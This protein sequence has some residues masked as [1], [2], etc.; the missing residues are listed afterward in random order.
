MTELF[1]FKSVVGALAA[2]ALLAG[3]GGA[4]AT[5]ATAPAGA[6]ALPATMPA[7]T[8]NLLYVADL[9]NNDVYVYTFPGGVLKRTLTGFQVPHSECVDAA[10]DVFVSD[11]GKSEVLEYR[12]GGRRPI[13]TFKDPNYFTQGCAV[14]PVTGDLAVSGASEGSGPSSIAIYRHAQKGTPTMVG[15]PNVFRVYFIGYDAKGD[16]FV[17]GTDMHVGFEFAEIPAGGKPAKAITLQ[18]SINL[19]GAVQWDGKHLAVG[20]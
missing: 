16:L 1:G 13:Q 4:G 11:G 20:D 19:P 8:G 6:P 7:A 17:D 18:Q 3:C 10:G 14:D 12:H 2:T 15:T 5:P 9:N